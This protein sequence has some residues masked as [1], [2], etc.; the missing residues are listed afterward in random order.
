MRR[1]NKLSSGTPLSCGR[2]G[3]WVLNLNPDTQMSEHAEQTLWCIT[4]DRWT[5]IPIK[6]DMSKSVGLLKAVIKATLPAEFSD[7]EANKLV[8]YGINVEL[9]PHNSITDRVR[10]LWEGFKEGVPHGVT[11]LTPPEGQK[12]SQ[13]FGTAPTESTIQILIAKSVAGESMNS[14]S[15]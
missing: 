11:L 6:I 13:V 2:C 9:E 4:A 7:L 3:R 8:L 1:F 10:A 12:L 5:T 14:T 15:V